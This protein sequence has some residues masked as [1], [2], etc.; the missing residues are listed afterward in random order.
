MAKKELKRIK[1]KEPIR[2]VARKLKDGVQSLM[3]CTYDRDTRT[4]TYES[5]KLFLYPEADAETKTANKNTL[6][7]A[8]AIVRQ[9]MDGKRGRKQGDKITF[10]DYLEKYMEWVHERGNRASTMRQKR[11]VA[12]KFA[13]V[14]GKKMLTQIDTK[15]I[16]QFIK[17]LRQEGKKENTVVQHIEVLNAM[18]NEAERREL[19]DKNPVR[20]MDRQDKPHKEE[21]SREYLS[22]EE[23]KR[24]MATKSRSAVVDAFLFAC[25][26]GLRFSDVKS[27]KWQEIR[28]EN[29]QRT[30][31]KTMQKTGGEVRVPISDEAW[32]I[33][34]HKRRTENVF[35]RLGS[36]SG[37]NMALKAWA[38]RAGVTKNVSFHVSRH[39]FATL[40]LEA[41]ADLYTVSKLLGH[42]E[43][44]TTQI[45]AKIVDKKR[46]EAVN[47]LAGL[48]C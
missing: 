29:G 32:D 43:I 17:K 6:A 30:I 3:I 28:E 21:S 10:C 46:Q 20:M 44:G 37:M 47:K 35:D 25:F 41:G 36:E 18:F 34:A 4:R 26:T 12:H 48:F 40:S 23:L 13:D 8:E 2:L 24:M 16:K 33:I 42:T 19:I 22:V 45:Y 9:R 27:L 5:L 31:V 11:I 39:T 14:A 15:D 1:S 7:L 38:N